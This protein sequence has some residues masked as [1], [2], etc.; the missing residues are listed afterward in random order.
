MRKQG[1]S[2]RLLIFLVAPFILYS[3]EDKLVLG[4]DLGLREGRGD[5]FL[6]R[7]FARVIDDFCQGR[8]GDGVNLGK[9]LGKLEILQA[10][11]QF[12]VGA[13]QVLDVVLLHQTH[14]QH[15]IIVLLHDLVILEELYKV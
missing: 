13:L 12:L 10:H 9:L 15:F 5:T 2:G 11:P 1:G 14:R 3:G 7:V 4:L 6:V 8:W